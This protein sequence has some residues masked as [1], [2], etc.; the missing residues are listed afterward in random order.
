[1]PRKKTAKQPRAPRAKKAKPES[2][3]KPAP[4]GSTALSFV[5]I[6]E[7]V[8]VS[9]NVLVSVNGLEVTGPVSYEEWAPDGRKLRVF[10]K[11]SPLAIGDWYNLGA[12]LF[13]ERASQEI[14]PLNGWSLA[15]L[16][17]YAW[18]ARQIAVD[19]RRMDRLGIRHHQLVAHLPAEKQREWLALAADDE[20]GPWK[21]ARLKKALEFGKDLKPTGWYVVVG[22]LAS[23]AAQERLMSKLSGDGLQVRASVKRS[24]EPKEKKK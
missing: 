3:A 9:D 10:E 4:A 24:A 15:T 7:R 19:D 2:G 23:A 1:M 13:G 20:E 6:I 11:A 18:V 8:R 21:V 12:Q 17:N 22:P 14:D 16:E 5:D